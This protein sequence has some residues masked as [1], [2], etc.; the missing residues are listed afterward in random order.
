MS[1]IVVQQ[2]TSTAST[3]TFVTAL[4]LNTD[5]SAD[6]GNTYYQLLLRY[7]LGKTGTLA[8]QEIRVRL[9]GAEVKRNTQNITSNNLEVAIDFLRLSLTPGVHVITLEHRLQT[10][11]SGATGTMSNAILSLTHVALIESNFR[12]VAKVETTE[13]ITENK[14]VRTRKTKVKRSKH[15]RENKE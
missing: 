15:H 1:N 13:T 14:E 7:N 9:D 4:T 3:A 2:G 11:S 6:A 5:T 8:S 12:A 10:F